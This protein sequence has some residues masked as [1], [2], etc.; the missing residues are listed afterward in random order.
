MNKNKYAKDGEMCVI[1]NIECK[2]K[3]SHDEVLGIIGSIEGV[4]YVEEL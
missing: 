4:D 1:L 3:R 2:E